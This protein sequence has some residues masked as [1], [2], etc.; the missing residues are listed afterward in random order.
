M[1]INFKE[2]NKILDSSI[3]ENEKQKYA[4]TEKARLLEQKRLE[5]M[6]DAAEKEAQKI[7]DSIPTKL[8]ESAINGNNKTLITSYV[9]YEEDKE[10]GIY[11]THQ[12]PPFFKKLMSKLKENNIKYAVEYP[13]KG[14]YTA[15]IIKCVLFINIKDNL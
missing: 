10:A 4:E 11:E 12:Q 14:E 9:Y 8:Q 7:F 5:E 1:A 2:L 6:E 13:K 3:E 15:Y